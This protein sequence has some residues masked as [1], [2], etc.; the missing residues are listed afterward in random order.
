MNL[1][2]I[3]PASPSNAFN[4]RLILILGSFEKSQ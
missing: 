3:N 1:A 2:Q 4:V